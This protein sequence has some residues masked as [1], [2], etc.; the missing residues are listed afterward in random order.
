MSRNAPAI[1]VLALLLAILGVAGYKLAPRAAS[2]GVTLAI[3]SCDPGLQACTAAIPGGGQLELAIAPR[4]I[5]ALQRLDLSVTVG[6][7]AARRVELDFAGSDMQMGYNRPALTGAAGQFTGQTT[8]PV[9]VS[10]NMAWVVT[11]L[12]DGEDRQI[13]IPFR[14]TVS[15]Y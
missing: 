10:G 5:K 15:G 2:A 7:L 11:V 3:S 6:G 12:L 4:P 13:A 14:F 9:C 1:T 8:L